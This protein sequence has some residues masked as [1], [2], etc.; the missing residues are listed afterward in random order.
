VITIWC[1]SCASRSSAALASSGS[2]K[3]SGHSEKARLAVMMM[4]PFSYRSA[5]IS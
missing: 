2:P 3:R 5:M 4:E 1:A